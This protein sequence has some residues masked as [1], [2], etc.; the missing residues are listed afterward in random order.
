MDYFHRRGEHLTSSSHLLYLR[1]KNQK[2]TIVFHGMR[3]SLIQ[4]INSLF[5]SGGMYGDIAWFMLSQVLSV[6]NVM[7]PGDI[8]LLN[9]L[10]PPQDSLSSSVLIPWVKLLAGFQLAAESIVTSSTSELLRVFNIPHMYWS[11]SRPSSCAGLLK[12]I[13]KNF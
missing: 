13:K 6:G 3:Q 2:I 10:F 4:K 8:A 1:R 12:I 5:I 7:L 9:F 11:T